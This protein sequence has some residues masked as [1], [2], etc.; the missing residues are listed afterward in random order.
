MGVFDVIDETFEK[1]EK[2]MDELFGRGG[3]FSTSTRTSSHR[4]YRV[5]QDDAIQI[6]IEVDVPGARDV[7]VSASSRDVLV[8]WRRGESQTRK[9]RLTFADDVKKETASSILSDGVL[10]MNFMKV[11]SERVDVGVKKT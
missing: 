11:R 4:C 6:V 9:L 10:I 2:S 7:K 5:V 1:F 3:F 8:E